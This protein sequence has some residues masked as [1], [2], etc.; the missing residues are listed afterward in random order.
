MPLVR[1]AVLADLPGLV[2]LRNH[3]V[4]NT[5]AT[6]D[7]ECHTVA[8]L[9]PWLESFADH[10]RYQLL[11]AD[12][13]G[14]VAG[15][16]CSQPYRPHPAFADTIETSIYIAPGCT[17]QGLGRTL[18]ETLFH[19]LREEPLH[20]ACVGIAL[21]NPGSVA[22]HRRFGFR[23]VGVFSEYARKNGERI[24]SVW[25]E[26]ALSGSVLPDLKHNP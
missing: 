25:M 8:S 26:R 7:T 19:A 18:Y 14:V 4:L 24:S 23:Q 15:Y 22:L 17:N 20:R 21:P 10:G 12:V 11:V 13:G 3:Y 9:R 16:C 5:Y 1:H 2:E 6:F